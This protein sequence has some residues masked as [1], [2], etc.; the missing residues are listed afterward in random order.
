M[1]ARRLQKYRHR[2]RHDDGVQDGLVA[3]TI[4]HHNIIRRH[5]MVPD[6]LVAGRCAV[7]DKKAMVG[8]EDAGRVALA[9]ANRTIVVQ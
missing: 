7:G 2:T 9:G 3:V 5:S 6:Y 1:V 8:V 4:N